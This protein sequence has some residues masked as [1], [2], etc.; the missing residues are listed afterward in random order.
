MMFEHYFLAFI[1]SFVYV[2][3]KAAQQLNVVHGQFAWV[4][5]ISIG[6]SLCE[7]WV[8]FATAKNGFGWLAVVIGLGSGLG[9][10]VSM[11]I[12]AKVRNPS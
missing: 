8:I 9:A 12:H 7:A 6:M 1:T 2:A 10:M 5:P 4:L 3:L 11:W